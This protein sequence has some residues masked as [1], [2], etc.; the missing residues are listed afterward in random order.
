MEAEASALQSQRALSRDIDQSATRA[1]TAGRSG[2]HSSKPPSLTACR[3]P[4][5][6]RYLY[7]TSQKSQAIMAQGGGGTPAPFTER[8]YSKVQLFCSN[9]PWSVNGKVR[10]SFYYAALPLA[11]SLLQG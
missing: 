7:F 8:P 2:C 3:L 4:S 6:R 5:A 9:L 11:P 1:E 10:A